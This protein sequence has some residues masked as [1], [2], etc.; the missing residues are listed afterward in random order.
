MLIQNLTW[1]VNILAL[2]MWIIVGFLI[3]AVDLMIN[4]LL[5]FSIQ[6]LHRQFPV[7]I[8]NLS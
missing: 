7:A 4:P 8:Y 5:G 6:K 2:T 3:S 1:D